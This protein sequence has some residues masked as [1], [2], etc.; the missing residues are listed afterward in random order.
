MTTANFNPHQFS[1]GP[2]RYA[3]S[4]LIQRYFFDITFTENKIFEV[5]DVRRNWIYRLS[6]KVGLTISIDSDSRICVCESYKVFW[7]W[8]IRLWD[9]IIWLNCILI[10]ST[11]RSIFVIFRSSGASFGKL[12]QATDNNTAR[13]II[14][15]SMLLNTAVTCSCTIFANPQFQE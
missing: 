7:S 14:N 2:Q 10:S 5:V 15:A 13:I 12:Q 6:K 9:W 3:C 8:I 11:S 4:C 1:D